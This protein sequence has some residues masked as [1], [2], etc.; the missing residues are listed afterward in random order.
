LN[1]PAFNKAGILLLGWLHVLQCDLKALDHACKFLTCHLF[2]IM[3]YI[4][5]IL[6]AIAVIFLGF[7]VRLGLLSHRIDM[8]LELG[9]FENIGFY[10]SDNSINGNAKSG[11]RMSAYDLAPSFP[12]REIYRMSRKFDRILNRF[13][14]FLG[15]L[16]LAGIGTLIVYNLMR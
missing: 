11:L 4:G 16:V 14:L 12:D 6:V 3:N 2:Q 13:Y 8:L 10:L 9:G 7:L 1:I 5:S 15:G